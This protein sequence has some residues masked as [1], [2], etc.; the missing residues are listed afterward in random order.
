MIS[1]LVLYLNRDQGLW[2]ETI[3]ELEGHDA[4]ELGERVHARLPIVVDATDGSHARDLTQWIL[5]LPGVDHIDVTYV[6]LEE[7]LSGENGDR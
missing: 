6:D 3:A 5:D 1:G 4:V 7:S 2:E